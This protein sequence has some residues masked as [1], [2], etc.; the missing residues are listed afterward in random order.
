MASVPGDLH[1]LESALSRELEIFSYPDRIWPLRHTGADGEHVFDVVIVGGGQAAVGT[2]VGLIRERITNILL[3]DENGSGEEGPWVTYARMITLRTAKNLPGP[4]GDLLNATFRA[5][6]EAQFGAEAWNRMN[7]IPKE[8]WMS[9]LQWLR[10]VMG[11]PVENGARVQRISPH[12]SG[13]RIEIGGANGL[14]Q[15]LARKVVLATGLGGA[16]GPRVPSL[17]TSSLPPER[18]AHSSTMFDFTKLEGKRVAVLGGNASAFDNAATALDHGASNVVHFIRRAQHPE[19]NTLRYLEFVGLFRNFSSLDDAMKL[20]F[21]RRALRNAIPPPPYSIERCT[22]YDN[23]KLMMASGW[24][25]LLETDAGVEITT[26]SGARHVVDFLILG[27]GFNVDLDRLDFLSELRPHI[28]LWSDQ[29]ALGDD[30]IDQEIGRHPYLGEGLQCFSRDPQYAATL[31]NLHFANGG[32]QVS[33]GPIFTG[34][35]GMPFM[36][37][38]LVSGISRDLFLADAEGFW[39]EFTRFDRSDFEEKRELLAQA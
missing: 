12:E 7:L 9:Y 38:R 26:L 13:F 1:E 32:S 23:Y 19:V 25:S 2:A 14:H 5:W 16:G 22:A 33:V 11:I 24:A 28:R 35:N 27:T 8:L 3:L 29:G 10:R 15:V 18:W 36:V 21:T 20:T 37:R 31:S 4:D 6:Y 34:I 17:V 30:P 39:E